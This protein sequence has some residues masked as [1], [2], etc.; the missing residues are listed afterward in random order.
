MA[1]NDS[2]FADAVQALQFQ[3]PSSAG[4]NAL[5]DAATDPVEVL[6]AKIAALDSPADELD[7]RLA[8]LD[9]AI[10]GVTAPPT[11][12][13]IDSIHLAA[14]AETDESVPAK[15]APSDRRPGSSPASST[16]M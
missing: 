1:Q 12:T 7:L 11:P 9:D 10:E 2:E 13:R 4:M 15:R 3:D 8:A 5:A 14:L 16:P 6:D